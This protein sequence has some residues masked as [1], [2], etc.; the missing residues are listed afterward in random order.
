[1][2][3][4]DSTDFFSATPRLCV[5]SFSK[6]FIMS[7]TR[8]RMIALLAALLAL[9]VLVPAAWAHP[10]GNFTVSRYT[11]LELQPEAV[12]LLYII[13]MAEIPTFQERPLMDSNGDGTVDNAEA[14][15]YASQQAQ[16]LAQN[17]SLTV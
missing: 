8:K 14:E 6:E 9:F 11:R 17:L 2:D 12:E 1:A 15:A 3:F 7:L 13:D 16:I 5:K 10:L 4:A